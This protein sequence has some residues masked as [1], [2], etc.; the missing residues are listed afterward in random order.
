MKRLKTDRSHLHAHAA[1][2]VKIEWN[3]ITP[4]EQVSKLG[5]HLIENPFEWL[6]LPI[7]SQC[8]P[9]SPTRR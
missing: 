4:L 3:M 5:S 9:G 7:L 8:Q 1:A 6:T 2:T